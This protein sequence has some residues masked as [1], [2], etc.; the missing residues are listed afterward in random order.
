VAARDPDC[1][2]AYWGSAMTR[3]HQL[4]DPPFQADDA[5][6]GRQEIQRAQQ[7][8]APSDRERRFI[9]ALAHV[10]DQAAPY[11]IRVTAYENAMK[12]LASVYQNDPEAQVF[13]ALALLAAASPWD[14]THSRQKQAAKILEPLFRTY[15]Q[16]PGIAHYLIHAYDSG[17]LDG[18]GVNA[19]RAYSKI[20]PS[21]PHALHMPSHIFTRLGMW[22][23]SIV[24][25]RAARI[26]AQQHRDKGEQLHAMDY[27]V[28]AYLQ[29]DR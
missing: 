23:E 26:A 21:A 10:Y 24:S 3:F 6:K 22:D 4:W 12:K 11:Q 19:A 13:Y 5:A 16:H 1:A 18:R 20:G 7:V 9:A 8:R 14:Q 28:Y 25:N 2:M 15:P 17:E 29:E 27:L